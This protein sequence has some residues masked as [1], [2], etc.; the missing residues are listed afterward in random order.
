MYFTITPEE[1]HAVTARPAPIKAIRE[2]LITLDFSVLL[3]TLVRYFPKINSNKQLT[4]LESLKLQVR[5]TEGAKPMEMT[6][7]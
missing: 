5:V 2:S 7:L 6:S 3:M 4:S 1:P